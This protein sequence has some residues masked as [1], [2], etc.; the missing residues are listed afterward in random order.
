MIERRTE[1]AGG[2]SPC[3]LSKTRI[4]GV[5]LIN[6]GRVLVGALDCGFANAML[7]RQFFA[8][9]ADSSI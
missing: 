4:N 1:R 5:A 2:A 3:I 7:V 6:G 9:F 8:M